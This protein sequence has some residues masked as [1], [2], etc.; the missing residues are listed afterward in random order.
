MLDQKEL[1]T[2]RE[3]ADKEIERLEE[4]RKRE[5]QRILEVVL[6]YI[7]YIN[8]FSHQNKKKNSFH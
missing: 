4:I 7:K 8:F 2:Q 3:K 5:Q 1:Q 6:M